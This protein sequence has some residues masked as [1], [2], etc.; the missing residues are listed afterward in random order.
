[1]HV[2]FSLMKYVRAF[3]V[4]TSIMGGDM[5]HFVCVKGNGYGIDNVLE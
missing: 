4:G 2:G 5:I 1:M 3:L